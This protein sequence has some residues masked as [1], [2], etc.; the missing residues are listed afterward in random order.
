MEDI[1]VAEVLKSHA[2][3]SARALLNALLPRAQY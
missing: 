1:K 3:R 2:Q